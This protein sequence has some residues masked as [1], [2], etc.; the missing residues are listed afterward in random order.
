MNACFANDLGDFD[1]SKTVLMN[2][3]SC[4]FFTNW[5]SLVMADCASILL[6]SL[7]IYSLATMNS[8]PYT[9]L[10]CIMLYLSPFFG[11]VLTIT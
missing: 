9:G 7:S 1:Q 2:A 11:R 8:L 10:V 4:F 6:S 5:T 3:I